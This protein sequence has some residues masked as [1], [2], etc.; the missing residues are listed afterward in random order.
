MPLE[1]RGGRVV[2]LDEGV[3]GLAQ[4]PNGG[5]AG[6]LEGAAREDREPDLDLVEPARVGGGEVKVDG[7]V[8]GQPAILLG[9]WVDRWSR[10]TWISCSG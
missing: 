7:L 9:L 8:P 5:E 2:G 1:G 4:L 10:T 3:D 6:A